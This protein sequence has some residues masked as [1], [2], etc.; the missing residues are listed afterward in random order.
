MELPGSLDD[1]LPGGPLVDAAWL[2]E[3]LDDSG[4]VVADVRWV[5]DGDASEA[6]EAGHIPGAV[7]LDAD[8]DLASRAF[9]DGPGRHPL[10]KAEAFARSM[11]FAGIGDSSVVVV[12]DDAGGSIAARLW[13]LLTLQEQSCAVLDGGIGAWR[14]DLETGP[15][16][17]RS[18][19]WF[20]PGEWPR[21]LVADADQV[22]TLLGNG[23]G[24][25]LDARVPERY[26]GETE[27]IDPVAGHIPGALNAP[28]PENLDPDTGRFRT[29]DELRSRYASLATGDG[30][31]VA[32]AGT[33]GDGPG[34]IVVSCG[35]GLTGT[36]DLLA[37]VV[38]GMPLGL[39][40]EGSWSGWVSDR[41]RP[42][43][44]GPD[45]WGADGE[46]AV[47]RDPSGGGEDS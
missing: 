10:P 24:V 17:A 26:R 14:G 42:V 36:H 5:P 47:A 27:P 4:L 11:S 23:E 32:R 19:G 31:R 12:Y 28:W 44:T 37:M 45:P 38:A 7:S 21:N 39:L 35:S 33:P 8:R 34:T 15:Q 13:W 9:V 22:A 25:V 1:E 30:T 6:F 40:Y 3:H 46:D 2:A 16:A 20:T 43:A 29:S 18:Q 41:S